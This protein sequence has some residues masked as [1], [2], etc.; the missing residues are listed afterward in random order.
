MPK[1]ISNFPA[2]APLA[3][4][5][6]PI[7]RPISNGQ[8]GVAKPSQAGGTTTMA[9]P[10]P[11][12][13][14]PTDV[15]YPTIRANGVEIPRANLRI[16]VQMARELLGWEDEGAYAERMMRELNAISKERFYYWPPAKIPPGR[17]NNP[18]KAPEFLFKDLA[19]HKVVLKNNV[20]NREFNLQHC[21]SLAQDVLNRRWRFNGE[22]MI[23]GKT[24]VT[25]SSQHRLV[26]LVLAGQIMGGVDHDKWITKWPE[27]HG[28]PPHQQQPWIE[29][30][31]ITG[32]EEDDETIRT[33]DNVMPRDLKDV[34][35]TSPIFA[36]LR[37]Q[38]KKECS[39][40]MKAAIDLHWQRT[41]AGNKVNGAVT[42]KTHSVE[43]DYV[44]N[45]PRL[46]D[47]VRHMHTENTGEGRAIS[48]LEIS[49]GQSACM[50][51]FMGSA[52]TSGEH[53]RNVPTPMDRSEDRLDWSLWDR[54]KEFW[55]MVAAD[56]P[57]MT[58]LR[59]ALQ[60]VHPDTGQKKT[61]TEK[62]AIIARAWG[63]F[64]KNHKLTAELDPQQGISKDL[65]LDYTRTLNDDGTLKD[66]ELA[67]CPVFGGIDLGVT[68]RQS[69]DDSK[70]EL[71]PE[72]SKRLAREAKEREVLDAVE[73]GKKAQKAGREKTPAEHVADIKS[74]F[75]GKTLLFANPAHG[76]WHAYG[77]QAHAVGL[78]CGLEPNTNVDPVRLSIMKMDAD[79]CLELL[80]ASP[81]SVV[82]LS[83]DAMTGA[84]SSTP[85]AKAAA[86]VEVIEEMPD[87]QVVE[88]VVAVPAAP[89]KQVKRK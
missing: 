9:R 13:P 29:A 39:R 71:T 56:K 54:A 28:L 18:D 63:H 46:A 23:I 21:M 60:F 66:Q 20:G 55:F 81:M 80:A 89:A 5:T 45:H 15:I 61:Q 51:Y 30:V 44:T 31:V 25:I 3:G 65:M 16:T 86:V 74:Q 82:R 59:Q 11:A 76:G 2:A 84:M 37:P 26:A 14:R 78:L 53:Y 87:G 88:E 1:V 34:I 57:A 43:M 62:H 10:Q 85:L 40:M 67:E 42:Y 47:C 12:V 83:W 72:K 52:A 48:V 7:P 27:L 32:V 73:K 38:A 8:A 33:I 6:G 58:P 69:E 50:L 22:A 35:S 24:G 41:G 79:R 70:D 77:D 36:D 68:I 4:G 49:A 19:G 75:P 64:L 17:E